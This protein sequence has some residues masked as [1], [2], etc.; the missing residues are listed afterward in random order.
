MILGKLNQVKD[1]ANISINMFNLY[2]AKFWQ[3]GKLEIYD[4]GNHWF[5]NMQTRYLIKF[6][7]IEKPTIDIKIGN[8]CVLT[9]P[10]SCQLYC[11]IYCFIGYL[12]L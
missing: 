2:F 12:P 6:D 10:A 8:C 1:Q 9:V 7:S 11:L 4:K 5:R 3:C